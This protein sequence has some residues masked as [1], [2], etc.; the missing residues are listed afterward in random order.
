MHSANSTGHDARIPVQAAGQPLNPGLPLPATVPGAPQLHNVVAAEDP[1]GTKRAREEDEFRLDETSSEP[2]IKQARTD[3]SPLSDT[4]NQNTLFDAIKAGDAEKIRRILTQC[5]SLRDTVHPESPGET[6]LCRAAR[7]GKL[8]IVSLLLQ[9]GAAPDARSSKGVTP[10]M[11]AAQAGNIEVIRKLNQVGA[12]LNAVNLSNHSSPALF[13]AAIGN[14]VEA[15]RCL[16]ELGANLAAKSSTGANCLAPASTHNSL[17]VVRWLLDQGLRIDEATAAGYTPL[18]MACADGHLQVAQLLADRGA[19]LAAKNSFGETCLMAAAVKNRPDVALWLLDRGISIDEPNIKGETPLL[20]ACALGHL[21]MAQLLARRGANLAAKNLRG[22]SCL[23]LATQRGP[24]ALIGWLL[25]QGLSINEQNAAGDTALSGASAGGRLEIVQLL[26]SRGANLTTQNARGGSALTWAVAKK[27]LAVVSWLLDQGLRIDEPTRQG[28]T[29]LLLACMSGHLELVQFLL[30]RGAILH[31][32]D[33]AGCTPLISAVSRNH[34]AVVRWLLDRGVLPD[35][36]DNQS[37]TPISIAFGSRYWSIVELLLP[38]EVNL[39]LDMGH[40]E[41][42]ADQM[43]KVAAKEGY[44]QVLLML[45]AKGHAAPEDLEASSG[46]SGIAAA[47]LRDLLSSFQAS[48]R[49]DTADFSSWLSSARKSGRDEVVRRMISMVSAAV[50]SPGDLTA[51]DKDFSEHPLFSHVIHSLL[52]LNDEK[53]ALLSRALAGSGKPVQ[54]AQQ[55]DILFVKLKALKNAP[56]FAA[57]FSGKNLSPDAENDRNTM[58]RQKLEGLLL[59]FRESSAIEQGDFA[60]HFFALCEKYLK[61]TGRF[62]APAFNKALAKHFGIVS[63]NADR[64]TTLVHRAVD[65]VLGKPLTVSAE[66]AAVKVLRQNGQQLINRLLAELRQLMIE[67]SSDSTL[68]G[69]SRGLEI[70]AQDEQETYA[71]V[72]FGQWRQI[73]AAFGVVLPEW[74]SSEQ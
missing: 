13:Y 14:Q 63:V 19:S 3:A 58:L 44:F 2:V 43:F 4:W 49:S 40:G 71:D 8:D 28:A 10:L 37:R 57:A 62:D 54:A 74:V 30:D 61:I 39:A 24:V 55:R 67:S 60:A 70:L 7:L 50:A 72:I 41:R 73:S 22:D 11:Y 69:F 66:E 36:P 34:P 46:L 21:E 16:V 51:Q 15:C 31:T 32:K 9:C 23:M 20:G 26:V 48:A 42:L 64:L 5:P 1:R 38:Y 6:P 17:D 27:Q 35:Q 59:A 47:A 68:P 56:E 45:M 65:A 12:D 25:D 53:F 33:H 29:P 52:N 18:M